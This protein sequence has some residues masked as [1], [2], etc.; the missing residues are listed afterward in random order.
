MVT[1]DAFPP[2]GRVVQILADDGA[3]LTGIRALQETLLAAG[4]APQVVATHKGEI[5]GGGRRA[6][7]LLVDRSFLTASSAEAD[8]VVVA[9]GAGLAADPA[10]L[11]FVQSAHRH[12]KTIAVWGDGAELL[13]AAGIAEGPGIVTATKSTKTFAAQLLD[14]MSLHRH[15]V[16][17]GTHPTLQG[18]S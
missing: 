2:D 11:T 4:A 17:A 6:D 9:G 10:A 18:R 1:A 7:S 5:G 14:A 8:A 12:H 15:W 16:R 13:A 3:D